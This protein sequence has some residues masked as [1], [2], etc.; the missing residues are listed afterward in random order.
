MQG[1]RSA[2][3]PSP[4]AHSLHP[5]TFTPALQAPLVRVALLLGV[6][7]CVASAGSI[8]GMTSTS[9]G[10]AAT[11]TTTGTN[12][13][14]LP[15]R[16]ASAGRGGMPVAGGVGF[17]KERTLGFVEY[18]S[19]D[20]LESIDTFDR[21]SVGLN[22]T[23]ENFFTFINRLL[24]EEVPEEDE[25]AADEE[26]ANPWEDEDTLTVKQLG[27]L[28]GGVNDTAVEYILNTLVR[29][30]CNTGWLAPPGGGAYVHSHVML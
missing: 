24:E 12:N 6:S 3:A 13:N 20:A 9:G 8:F 10:S 7:A 22:M 27:Q 16:M 23:I 11:T 30:Y 29:T 1:S 2:H 25:A 21:L 4:L 26:E 15:R 18:L 28:F 19:A 5:S 17:D 14:A